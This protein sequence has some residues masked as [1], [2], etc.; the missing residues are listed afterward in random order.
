M[1]LPRSKFLLIVVSI[2]VFSW[3][4]AV[5]TSLGQHGADARPR[6]DGNNIKGAVVAADEKEVTVKADD[7][8]GRVM[9]IKVPMQRLVSGKW[10]ADK[11]IAGL[12]A[13]LK[14]GDIVDVDY[15][16]HGEMYIIRF[17]KK[18][19]EESGVFHRDRN[20]V[21]GWVISSSENDV[22]IETAETDKEITLRVPRRRTDDGKWVKNADI[23]RVAE[24]LP[25]GQLIMAKY[26]L[27]DAPGVFAILNIKRL[28]FANN[29]GR[30][31]PHLAAQLEL[32]E[33]RLAQIQKIVKEILGR[34]LPHTDQP[35]RDQ[36]RD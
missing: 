8:E 13:G 4:I 36:P 5:G 7:D 12:T 16:P 3:S 31:R 10:V 20:I 29:E 11:D 14:P 1:S 15:N 25:R 18:A 23:A 21:T 28:S 9:V 33:R 6:S 32:L 22:K 19:G 2:L 34:E 35:Y 30:D 17:I 24:K 26:R 27:T